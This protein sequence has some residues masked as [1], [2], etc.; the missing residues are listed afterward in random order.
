VRASSRKKIQTLSFV[1]PFR[2]HNYGH[3]TMNFFS[4][5]FLEVKHSTGGDESGESNSNE[6]EGENFLRTLF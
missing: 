3:R 2:A 4:L 1:H 5:R 6:K